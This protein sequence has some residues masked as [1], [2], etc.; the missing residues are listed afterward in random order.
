MIKEPEAIEVE[1]VQIDGVAPIARYERQED[2]NPLPQQ[3]Q[4]WQKW[5]GRI[6]KLDGRWWPLWVFLGAI[7]LVLVLTVGVVF[8]IVFLIYSILRGFVRALVR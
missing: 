3:R 4:D 6:R 7:A 8:G 1:V 2:T 5:Q